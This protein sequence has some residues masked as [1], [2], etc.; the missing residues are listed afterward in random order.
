MILITGHKGFLGSRLHD[1]LHE[2][3]IEHDGVDLKDG[4]N[5]L[6]CE[7]PWEPDIIYHLAAQSSVEASWHDPVHDLDNIRITARLVRAY[8]DA[9]IIYANSCASISHKTP[10]GF[11]KWAAREYLDTF[12]ANYVDCVFPNIYG[13]GSASVVDIFAGKTVAP[14]FGDGL[15]VRDYVHVD[16]IIEGLLKAKNWPVGTYFM[17]SGVGTRVLDLAKNRGIQWLPAREEER[18]IVVPNT[19]PDWEPTINV[20]E[21]I[22]PLHQL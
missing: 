14:I 3:G 6:T 4:Q 20:M 22:E 1:K 15:A 5:L 2:L 12:H 16:D 9:K 21:Y 18:E 11:S 10:Y 8:P 7:L 13:P 17:G 19:T